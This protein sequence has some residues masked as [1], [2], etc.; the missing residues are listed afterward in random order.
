MGNS[1][2]RKNR[3]VHKK[4]IFVRKSVNIPLSR[5]TILVTSQRMLFNNPLFCHIEIKLF[6]KIWKTPN[7]A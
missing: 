5:M 6:S 3:N 1:C 2:V 4:V 7:K